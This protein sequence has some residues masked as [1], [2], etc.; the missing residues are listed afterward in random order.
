MKLTRNIVKCLVC[1][2]VIESRSN[3]DHKHCSCGRL[4]VDGGTVAPRIIG[5]EKDYEVMYEYAT[6]DI[7]IIDSQNDL[8][9]FDNVDLD[10]PVRA[11]G[12]NVRTLNAFDYYNR[13]DSPMR[14][15]LGSI[16]TLGDLKS[17]RLKDLL[18]LRNLGEASVRHIEAV[19]KTLKI[20]L[21][22]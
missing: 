1:G 17:Y 20:K 16:Y 10:I 14:K 19:L 21:P 22:S 13:S 5:E 6:Q 9:Q 8:T 11:M 18:M 4:S 3:Y 12:F 7:E 15:Q 2:D